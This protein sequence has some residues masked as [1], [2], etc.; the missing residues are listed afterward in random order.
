MVAKVIGLRH[1]EFQNDK[2]ETVKGKRVYIEYE[3]KSDGVVGMCCDHKYFPL[4]G[5]VKLPDF[6]IGLKYDFVYKEQGF[7]GKTTLVAIEPWTG[8]K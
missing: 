2:N 4:D 5:P 6:V 3:D 7:T 8:S 1:V